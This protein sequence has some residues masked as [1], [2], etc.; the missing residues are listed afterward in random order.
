MLA[1][2]A[3][4]CKDWKTADGI[5]RNIWQKELMR[6]VPREYLY[7]RAQ[8]YINWGCL[9]NRLRLQENRKHGSDANV[10]MSLQGLP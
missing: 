3:A 7:L 4:Q 10:L 1:N 2:A 9:R 8:V 6:E 5:L